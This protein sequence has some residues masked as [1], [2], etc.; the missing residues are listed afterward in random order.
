MMQKEELITKAEAILQGGGVAGDDLIMWQSVL[1][2]VS[3]A[4]VSL[5]IDIMSEDE[6]ALV[7]LTDNLK[8]K[9]AA[10]DD[11]AK[12]QEIVSDEEAQLV[13]LI[14]S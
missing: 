11:P 1:A 10:G 2:R 7:M 12:I 14:S 9:I 4:A 6:D 5:F 3:S 13:E 8:K